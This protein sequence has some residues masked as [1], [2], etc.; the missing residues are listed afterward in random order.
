[1]K[2]KIDD[3]EYARIQE[4]GLFIHDGCYLL[5]P[6]KGPAITPEETKA[7]MRE[8]VKKMKACEIIIVKGP[9]S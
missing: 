9:K 3:K 5:K 2:F 8:W 7:K 1:M 6:R 4:E